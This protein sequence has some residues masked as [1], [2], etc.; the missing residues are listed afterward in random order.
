MLVDKM[1]LADPGNCGS[2]P[3][4]LPVCQK[5]LGVKFLGGII[6]PTPHNTDTDVKL[7]TL[8]E[9]PVNSQ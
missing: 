5:S 3:G 8:P 9:K 6:L 1:G 7:V 2:W 4:E